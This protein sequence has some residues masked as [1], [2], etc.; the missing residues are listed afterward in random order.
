MYNKEKKV[1]SRKMQMCIIGLQV[2]SL[3]V[4]ILV[5][6]YIVRKSISGTLDQS[7]IRSLWENP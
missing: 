7:F 6:S 2:T 3:Q 1:K 5:S 4:T